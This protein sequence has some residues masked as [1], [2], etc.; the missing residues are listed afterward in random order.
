MNLYQIDEALTNCIDP[1]TGEIDEERF[2]ELSLEKETKIE[3]IALWIKNLRSDIVALK[4]EETALAERRKAAERKVDSLT[5]YLSNYCGGKS[6]KT[7]RYVISFRKSEKTIVDDISEIPEEYISV[8]IDRKPDLNKLKTAIKN[9]IA[10][11][12]CHIE[13]N[14]NINIK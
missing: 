9:G 7:S 4:A 1:E 10:V 12:G 3:N 13:E 6:Y 2:N 14:Q 11:K 5:H 8:K